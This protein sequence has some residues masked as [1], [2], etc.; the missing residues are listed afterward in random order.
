M[1]TNGTKGLTIVSV[2]LAR[3]IFMSG[4][5]FLPTSVWADM[6]HTKNRALKDKHYGTPVDSDVVHL[7]RADT[8]EMY[9]IVNCL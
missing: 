2:V 5:I 7:R 8:V 9:F 3:C 1:Q 4:M 6:S